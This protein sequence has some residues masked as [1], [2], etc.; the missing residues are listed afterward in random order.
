MNSKIIFVFL[1]FIWACDSNTEKKFV[2]FKYPEVPAI[3]VQSSSKNLSIKSDTV[4]HEKKLFS[5]YIFELNGKDTVSKIGYFN[6]L[7]SG[8]TKKWYGKN[9]LSEKRYYLKGAKNGKQ[10][11]FWENGKKK[12]E[13]FAKNDA[14]EGE[15]KEWDGSGR[16]IHLANFKNGQEEGTQKLW[17]DNGKI[18]ANYV[19]RNGKKYGLLGTKNCINVSDS[20]F[21]VK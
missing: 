20:I 12:F 10:I 1:I 3:Y 14:Y 5:G 19:M 9:V 6:G 7:L 4:F 13:F 21:A 18:R 2:E 11:A 8:E 16:L 17:Y 15:L